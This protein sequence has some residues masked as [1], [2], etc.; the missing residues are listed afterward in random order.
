MF[1]LPQEDSLCCGAPEDKIGLHRRVRLGWP[2]YQISVYSCQL[3]WS[4]RC[5]CIRTST[6]TKWSIRAETESQS[7][8]ICYEIQVVVILD[9]QSKWF[10]S[11]AF[12]RSR[13]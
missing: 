2:S 4:S 8:K 9:D 5:T 13:T 3:L 12:E 1:D 10:V 6:A 7:G 11:V